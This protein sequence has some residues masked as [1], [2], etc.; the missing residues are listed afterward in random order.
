[1]KTVSMGTSAREGASASGGSHSRMSYNFCYKRRTS[2]ALSLSLS[3][4]GWDGASLPH[5]HTRRRTWS[6][7]PRIVWGE[8]GWK[9]ETSVCMYALP[10][11]LP[12]RSCR[13][14]ALNTTLS[15]HP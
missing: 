2:L 15:R 3:E 13:R 1:M 14:G 7:P 11:S 5:T 9:E 4:T 12:G 6:G 8:E 10:D